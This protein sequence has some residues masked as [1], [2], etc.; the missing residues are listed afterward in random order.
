M[1]GFSGNRPLHSGA[2][3]R[4]YADMFCEHARIKIKT[5]LSLTVFLTFAAP[6]VFAAPATPEGA[7]HL[8]EVF[9]RYLG[10]TEG[11][12]SVTAG[13]ETYTATIDAA[14][15]WRISLPIMPPY[16]CRPWF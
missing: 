16:P 15:R 4:N 6:A 2:C 12:G 13:G 9:R 7:T 8:T 1:N 10:A 14:T 11:V 5:F 3:C